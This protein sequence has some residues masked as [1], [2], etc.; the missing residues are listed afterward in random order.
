MSTILLLFITL[1]ILKNIE[2]G[3]IGLIISCVFLQQLKGFHPFNLYGT[4]TL[5]TICPILLKYG[6]N[7]FRHLSQFPLKWGM[8]AVL[9]S[10]IITNLYVF[11]VSTII[12]VFSDFVL[13]Y[14]FWLFLNYTHPKQNQDFSIRFLFFLGMILALYGFIEVL[15][16]QNSYQYWIKQLGL[17][18]EQELKTS[19]RFGFMRCFTFFSMHTTSGCI[20]ACYGITLLLISTLNRRIRHYSY[21]YLLFVSFALLAVSFFSGSRAVLMMVFMSMAMFVSTSNTKTWIFIAGA[22]ICIIIG[23]NQLLDVVIKSILET[24]SVVGS[25]SDMRVEQLYIAWNI[26]KESLLFGHGIGYTFTELVQNRTADLYGAE[27]ILFS[28]LIDRGAFGIVSYV[29][30][31]LDSIRYCWNNNPKLSIFPI[32]FVTCNLMT[33]LPSVPFYYYIAFLVLFISVHNTKNGT[34]LYP[35]QT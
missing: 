33:S 13:Y 21:T 12:N 4:V 34:Q 14:Y 3:V 9:I 1:L 6:T 10:S 27:S 22:S 19:Y 23:A 24:D 32:A 35:K 25:N 15:S 5:I 29:V 28:F 26:A 30:L 11:H 2:K 20:A 7:S 18:N 31:L 16:E 17:V 8:F